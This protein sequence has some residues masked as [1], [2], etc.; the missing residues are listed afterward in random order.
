MSLC[1]LPFKGRVRVGM[2]LLVQV[3][4]KPIPIP[5]FPLKG[6]EKSVAYPRE[7]IYA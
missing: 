3:A 1:S 5:A 7:N 4:M 2:G 6:K